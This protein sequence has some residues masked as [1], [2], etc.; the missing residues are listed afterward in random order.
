[1]KTFL[2]WSGGKDSAYCLYLAKQ[3]GLEVKALV[4]TV[5]EEYNRVS[6][7]GVPK[8]M[9]ELQAAS[10]Q[11]PLHT[12]EL[13]E[14]PGTSVFEEQIHQN[15]M[16][17]KEQGFDTAVFGDI[18]L[19]DLRQYREALYQKDGISCSFPLWKMD[20]RQL[21][22]HLI[23][24]GFKP[25]VVCVDA[26]RLDQSFCGRLLDES[27][28]KDLPESVDPCGENGEYHSFVFD[29]PIFHHPVPYRKGDTVF[30]EYGGAPFYFCELGKK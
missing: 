3:Q 8:E 15:N 13:P 10:I 16:L 21:V 2:S 28:I 17:L 5:N 7:H 30:R 4:T 25:I 6:M 18:F 11:L 19:E 23:S 14:A 22:D 20:S 29:G 26:T 24:A 1:M 9:V 12:I 27:F